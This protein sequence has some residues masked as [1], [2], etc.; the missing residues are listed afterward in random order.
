MSRIEEITVYSREVKQ[1]ASLL[2]ESGIGGA[3]YSRY[4]SAEAFSRQRRPDGV[5]PLEAHKGRGLASCFVRLFE[6]KA[7]KGRIDS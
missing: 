5:R 3:P 4:F 1:L 2:H 7:K 6:R